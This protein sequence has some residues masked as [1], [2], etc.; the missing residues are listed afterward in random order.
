MAKN[1][2][3]GVYEDKNGTYVVKTTLTYKDGYVKNITKRGFVSKTEAY[4]YKLKMIAEANSTYYYSQNDKNIK[5]HDFFDLYF[6]EYSITFSASTTMGTKGFIDNYLKVGLPNLPLDK[7]TPRHFTL[8]REFMSEQT[9]LNSNSK[10]KRLNLLKRIMQS[11]VDKGYLDMS[12]GRY[13]IVE[14]KPFIDDGHIVQNDY[15]EYEEFQAFI[16]SFDDTDKYKLLFTCLFSFGCRIGEFRA[17]QWKDFDP[18]KNQIHIYKQVS[19]KLGTGKWEIIPNTKTKRER[20]TTISNNLK[21][22]LLEFKIN[23]N[24]SDED[25]LFFGKAPISE[26]AIR[27]VKVKHCEIAGVKCIR[28]HDFRHTYITY[29]LDN[30]L[31]IKSVSAQVGHRDVNTTLNIYNHITNTRTKKLNDI[32]DD[33]N[34]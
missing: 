25:F 32:L 4:N 10:N 13:F 5:L 31:D 24:F 14:L 1:K 29:L 28:N 15:W 18:I 23:N 19:S 8:F 2:Y 21:N 33:L 9:Q 20:Y 27:N 6:K 34:I 22:K 17:L 11:A 3:T 12:I 30:Q 7:L 16:N 26:N